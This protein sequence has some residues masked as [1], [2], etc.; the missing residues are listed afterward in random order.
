M[1]RLSLMLLI[2]V[3]L[4]L[5]GCGKGCKDGKPGPD[6][7]SSGGPSKPRY[8]LKEL[9]SK[10][11]EPSRDSETVEYKD[12][13]KVTIPGGALTEPRKVTISAVKDPPSLGKKPLGELAC[14]DISAGKQQEF[15]VP[16]LIEIGYDPSKIDS[17]VPLEEGLIAA[18]WNEAGNAWQFVR[19]AV[20]T[21]SNKALIVTNHLCIWRLYYLIKGYKRHETK[22]FTV[23]YDEA[24]PV[25]APT[26]INPVTD[27]EMTGYA[28][29]PGLA[30]SAGNYLEFARRNYIEA[31]FRSPNTLMFDIDPPSGLT[32]EQQQQWRRAAARG[33]T[34]DKVWVFI[35]CSDWFVT[36]TEVGVESET[37][38]KTGA[39]FLASNY[40]SYD[41]LRHEC[42]HELF[43]VIQQKYL[44]FASQAIRRW[45][46]EATADYA[47]DKVGWA[48]QLDVMG[49]EFKFNFID[50]PMTHLGREGTP[51]NTHE[52]KACRFIQT[53]VNNGADF[54]GIWDATMDC[55][56]PFTVLVP[57]DKY[58]QGKTGKSLGQ[59]YRIFAAWM[60]FDPTGPM[61]D[62]DVWDKGTY[63][64][65]EMKSS[66]KELTSKVMDLPMDLTGKL[67]GIRPEIDKKAGD[68]RKLKVELIEKET[69]G[70]Y[71]DVFVLK[72]GK[73]TPG[74]TPSDTL[75]E[76]GESAKVE[77]SEGDVLY[78]LATNSNLCDAGKAKVKVSDES[79]TLTV[80][81][82]KLDQADKV[83][84]FNFAADAEGF[85]KDVTAAEYEVDWGD[86][87]VKMADK[88][89]PD[90]KGKHTFKVSHQFEKASKA[91]IFKIFDTTKGVKKLLAQATVP[92]LK[93]GNE[94]VSMSMV[95]QT[96]SG[97]PEVLVSF[98]V[99]VTN[100][101]KLAYYEW[102][103]GD[104]SE[105]AKMDIPMAS[106][107]YA[108]VGTY[109]VSIRLVDAATGSKLA[110]TTGEA[111][112][113]EETKKREIKVAKEYWPDQP[114]KL[115]EEYEYYEYMGG[116]TMHGRYRRFHPDT[117][118]VISEGQY[119][120][121]EQEGR[122]T[123]KGKDYDG[124]G[125]S[126]EETGSYKEGKQ[127]G[128]WTYTSWFPGGELQ[129]SVTS[130]EN[131]KQGECVVNEMVGGKVLPKEKGTYRNGKK[132]GSWTTYDGGVV[133]QEM[134]Y[135]DDQL[136]GTY[137]YYSWRTDRTKGTYLWQK[138][139]FSNG[140]AL[141]TTIYNQDGSVKEEK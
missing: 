133:K 49:A 132:N 51:Y 53:C 86:G 14:Y 113:R 93:F 74:V 109:A 117:G 1:R 85:S 91:V 43:H 54:K 39:V 102:D 61:K 11:I 119:V 10:D 67:W 65:D 99:K 115:M 96:V 28:D 42:A 12:E 58:L 88:F 24:K 36:S 140:K 92:I 7:D 63:A 130:D 90:A 118:E 35:N 19:V 129:S 84:L 3:F 87:A 138:T 81:P 40:E 57:L 122:W 123:V 95:P 44:T 8:T 59:L 9:V 25:M 38:W 33:A 135:A 100:G 18:N 55:P 20:D 56:V 111:N 83:K 116:R 22:N 37:S 75:I 104:G 106:H 82:G 13:V 66:A 60:L 21:Q 50:V 94:V 78:I 127:V 70:V 128:I 112:I 41:Q 52:Y 48:G 69:A 141:R 89:K 30:R 98:E 79:V 103:F 108:K 110:E 97:K 62:G 31:G 46:M 6:G 23:V 134:T 76:K 136:N 17:D 120:E 126:R 71:V 15:E 16:L 2:S 80:K 68:T 34:E 29:M 124:R 101:P 45:W 77:I 27:K 105:R 26:R 5:T 131:G 121:G 4:I 64:K 107:R 137:K 32:P 139:E 73:R 47:A 125:S 114:G 72:G